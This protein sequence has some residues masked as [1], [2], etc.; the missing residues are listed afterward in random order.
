VL[1]GFIHDQPQVRHDHSF[2]GGFNMKQIP[3]DTGKVKIGIY[4]EPKYNYY[5]DDQDWIQKVLLG[6]KPNYLEERLFVI[7]LY[8]VVLY[9]ATGLLTRSWYE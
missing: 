6:I 5:N 1:V 3:Y 9:V 7:T 4:Y 8:A 2:N